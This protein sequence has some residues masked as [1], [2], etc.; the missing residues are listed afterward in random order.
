MAEIERM[1]TDGV[2]ESELA[3]AKSHL[4]GSLALGLED[5]GARWSRIGHS[6]L[7]HGRVPDLDEV[8]ART[9]NLTVDQVN[10]V[11]RRYLAQP[12]TLAAVGPFGDDDLATP[13]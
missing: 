2:T 3:A 11:A 12:V 5:S 8:E 13:G 10:A 1:A 9:A 7:I 4:R 6:Q